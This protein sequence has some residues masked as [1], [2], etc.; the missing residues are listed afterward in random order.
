MI[1]DLEQT[2]PVPII[3]KTLCNGCGLCV[4]ACPGDALI[5]QAGVAA[6]SQASACSYEGLCE[7]ICPVRAIARPFLIVMRRTEES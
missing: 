6:V 7:L 2:N 3:D 5:M 1:D 4:A